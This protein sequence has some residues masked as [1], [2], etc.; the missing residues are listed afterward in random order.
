MKII[1]KTGDENIAMVYMAET[2]DGKLIEFV[3]SVQPPIPREKKWILTL[4]TLYG[5]PVGCRFCDAGIYYEGKLSKDD[6]MSQIDYLIAS[7]FPDREVPVPKFKIQFARMGEPSFNQN[8]L[9]VL[10]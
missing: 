8:V 6:I 3:E 1:V 5:C 2:E 7:R 4:S 10:Q 9:N